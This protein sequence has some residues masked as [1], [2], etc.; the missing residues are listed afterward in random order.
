MVLAGSGARA[1]VVDSFEQYVPSGYRAHRNRLIEEG[2]LQKDEATGELRFTQDEAFN[3]STEA[4]CV[5]AG[6][7]VNGIRDWFV[8][9]PDGS[10]KTHG[11]WLAQQTGQPD[12]GEPFSF[13]WLP[14]FTALTRHLIAHRDQQDEV[15]AAFARAATRMDDGKLRQQIERVPALDP[16]TGL[17]LAASYFDEDKRLRW[18]GLIGEEL[19]LAVP[20]PTTGQDLE[21]IY[22][23]THYSRPMLWENVPGAQDILFEL[24]AQALEGAV[25]EDTLQ[26]AVQLPDLKIN[27]ISQGLSWIDPRRYAWQHDALLT[28]P[29]APKKVRSAR[30]YL[31]WMERLAEKFLGRFVAEVSQ[32]TRIQAAEEARMA[33]LNGAAFPFAAFLHDTAQYAADTPKGN[34]LLDRRYGQL[35]LSLIRDDD[36]D[37]L[38]PVSSPYSG[39]TQLAVK[40]GLNGGAGTEVGPFARA[41]L[42]AQESYAESVT[43]PPGL[44]M[45][46]GIPDAHREEIRAA[47]QNR[48]VREAL[49]S[50]LLSDLN[51]SRRPTLSLNSDFPMLGTIELSGDG[52]AARQAL[53]T[54]LA[55]E[56]K[57]CRLRVGVTLD[58]EVLESQDFLDT[59]EAALN[60][61][62]GVL[63]TLNRVTQ[64]A[65]S[66]RQQ[67]AQEV[68]TIETAPALAP[69]VHTDFVPIPGVAFNQILY[70]PPGTGKTYAV[71]NRALAVL[72]PTFSEAQVSSRAALKVRYDQLVSEGRVSFVTFHQSFGYEDFIEGI[73]PVMSGGQLSYRLEDGVFL[74]AVRAAGGVLPR[75]DEEEAAKP[76]PASIQPPEVNPGGQVWRI[77]IDGTVPVSQ[78]RDRSLSRG[79]IRVGSWGKTPRNLNDLPE[80]GLNAQQHAF[81]DSIRTGDL[82][83]LATRQDRIGAI[84]VVTGEY[85]FDPHSDPVFALDYAHARPVRWLAQDLSLDAQQ[86]TGKGF[87]QQTL[88]RVAGVTPPQVLAHLAPVA[89]GESIEAVQD[90][91][92]VVRPHVLIIDEINRGNVAKIFGELLTLLEADKRTG[93]A[94]ALTV[95]LP[96][97][98]R[99]LGIPQSLYVIGTMNTADR[100]LTLLDAALRRRFVFHPVWPKPEVLPVLTF[101]DGLSIDLRKFL[102]AI[103]ARIERLLGREQMIGHAYLLGLPATLEGVASALRER[104]L[105]LLEEYFFEDWGK[106][107]EVLGDDGKPEGMQFIERVGNGPDARYRHNEAAFTDV[108]A[109][110]RVYSNLDDSAFHFD[111]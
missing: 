31:T 43:Y 4:G 32:R 111:S 6:R 97:S 36:F 104:I 48:E 7:M 79:E 75:V 70:G 101:K 35:L 42:F 92:P 18:M 86:V 34:M 50:A 2:L 9:L 99:A 23:G 17:S 98:R 100:S 38:K 3:G 73:K 58:P 72:D 77:Y 94:E 84:G 12:W 71:V 37:H 87:A 29:G 30:E 5:V 59:L 108:E 95:T 109:F 39:K 89:G 41:M 69:E 78:V 74:E 107:R 90:K 62:D 24:A 54:Y 93:A 60:Y 53:D 46:V 82:V 33:A 83:L 27:R 56:G 49:I 110:V 1:D 66:R 65:G 85:R 61:T 15:R 16:F 63:S 76:A 102:Y 22:P 80:D 88:Q 68:G 57:S 19:A 81:K 25:Q 44:T 106:I 47:L 11:E 55:G 51:L 105:P 20:A 8:R 26:A 14:F 67:E 45:E 52:H 96:L 103:N 10:K 64:A 91:A 28:L 13:A 21:G 40:L